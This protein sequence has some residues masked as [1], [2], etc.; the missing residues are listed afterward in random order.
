VKSLA[1]KSLSESS[2]RECRLELGKEGAVPAGEGGST[3]F[4]GGRE[5]IWKGKR[6]ERYSAVTE[7]ERFGSMGVGG[8]NVLG[9]CGGEEPPCRSRLRTN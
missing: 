9:D 4:A 2:K 8:F 1:A 6:A 3:G 5:G 7:S